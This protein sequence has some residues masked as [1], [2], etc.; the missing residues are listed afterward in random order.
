LTYQTRTWMTTMRELEPMPVNIGRCQP[1]RNVRSG[2]P[3]DPRGQ[4]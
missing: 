4:G 2:I 3:P 1:A